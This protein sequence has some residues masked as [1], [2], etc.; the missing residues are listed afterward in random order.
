MKK[1]IHKILILLES[2]VVALYFI[3]D[4]VHLL[5]ITV[6]KRS[7]KRLATISRFKLYF[8]SNI[9]EKAIFTLIHFHY[10]ISIS[11]YSKCT[12]LPQKLQVFCGESKMIISKKTSTKCRS[13][14][15]FH[16]LRPALF[17][18]LGKG[19]SPGPCSHLSL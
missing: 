8:L 12:D 2:D 4:I 5:K 13:R 3:N 15:N 17:S 16:I 9:I 19:M 10:S 14:N 7:M 18:T 1:G 6:F 11:V